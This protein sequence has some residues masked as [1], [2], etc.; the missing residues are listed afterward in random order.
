MTLEEYSLQ[1]Q[2]ISIVGLIQKRQEYRNHYISYKKG[3]SVH[4]AT[5]RRAPPGHHRLALVPLLICVPLVYTDEI[6][7]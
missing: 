5:P 4:H 2:W 7:G 3:L 1:K 6:G